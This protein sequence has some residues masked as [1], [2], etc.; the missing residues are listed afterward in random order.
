MPTI[1]LT[2]EEIAALKAAASEKLD[3]DG[4]PQG[5]RFGPLRSALA[6]L[7]PALVPRPTVGRPPLS[8]DRGGRRPRR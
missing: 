5:L 8:R 6:K 2:E 7:D 3:K 1:D 4:Y